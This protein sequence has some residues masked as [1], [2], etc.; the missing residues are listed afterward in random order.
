MGRH[1]FII[2]LFAWVMFY[3]DVFGQETY[4]VEIA[5]IDL[6]YDDNKESF[7]AE[8][9]ADIYHNGQLIQPGGNYYYKWYVYYSKEEH[10]QLSS[11]GFGKYIDRPETTLGY[12]IKSYVVVTDSVSHTFKNIQSSITDRL[13]MTVRP[14]SVEFSCYLEN[15]ELIK[16]IIPEHWRNT[17]NQWKD[18]YHSFL[19][20]NQNAIIRAKPNYIDSLQEKFHHC[21]FD[22]SNIIH[23]K[24]FFIDT[25]Q[26]QVITAHYVSVKEN[27]VIKTVLMEG[28]ES[29][30]D[31]IQ[32]KD[33]WVVDTTDSK[34]YTQPFGYHSLGM[35]TPFLSESSP[36]QLTFSSKYQG[37]FLNQGWPTWTPPYYSVRAAQSQVIPFH[38][39]DIIWYFQGWKGED[40]QFQHPQNT[41]TAVVF[42]RANALVRANY[43]SHLVSNRRA[44]TAAKN[45]WR[46]IS[47]PNSLFL[48]QAVYKDDGQIYYT[49]FEENSNDWSDVR[50]I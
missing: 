13:I 20:E 21:N 8:L 39:Q 38:G 9:R 36:L 1:L 42:Q 15:G 45:N 46:I 49:N 31:S 33:P 19:P 12:F 4:T 2:F 34:F 28:V 30:Y 47:D 43:K 16:S 48:W 6:W 40:V 17:V 23:Y 32:F 14:R 41:T 50:S 5:V 26:G 18:G 3:S 29:E 35:E 25:S 10:W 11:T 27:V 22:A 24:S 44:A 7:R 37:V